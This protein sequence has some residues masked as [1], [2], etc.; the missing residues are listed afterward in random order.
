[1]RMNLFGASD[2]AGGWW[3]PLNAKQ[4]GIVFE[5]KGGEDV[6]NFL[7]TSFQKKNLQNPREV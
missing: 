1:M 7:S 4:S 3:A 6:Y 2:K 5:G